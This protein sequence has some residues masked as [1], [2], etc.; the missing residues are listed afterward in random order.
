LLGVPSLLLCLWLIPFWY[1]EARLKP[2]EGTK[3]SINIQRDGIVGL[4]VAGATVAAKGFQLVS[5]AAVWLMGILSAAAAALTVAGALF[6]FTGRGLLLQAAWA[7]ILAG[8]M[9]GGALMVSFLVLT[10]LRR[11]AAYF[12]LI[13]LG[14]SI[15]VLWVLV[16]RFN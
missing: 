15:Y 1:Q 10:S 3:E 9:S 2:A 14:L 6:F 11:G 13:P 5:G 12:A 7:R 8:L 4:V 16:R